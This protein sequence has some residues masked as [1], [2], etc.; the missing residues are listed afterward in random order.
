MFVQ[1][2]TYFVKNADENV[3]QFAE[4]LWGLISLS[5]LSQ[6]IKTIL[7]DCKFVKCVEKYPLQKIEDHEKDC[8]H[9]PMN[10]IVS[11]PY[12]SYCAE[13]MPL[14]K[15]LNHLGSTC[16]SSKTPIVIGSSVEHSLRVD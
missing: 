16:S 10:K 3:A 14:P 8:E 9:N 4:N 13:K 1:M 11:C 2:V 7:H 15:L 6:K 12:Y 5:S